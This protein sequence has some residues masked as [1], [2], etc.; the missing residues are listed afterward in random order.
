MDENTGF[1]KDVSDIIAVEA[2]KNPSL[3]PDLSGEK[4]IFIFSDYSWARGRYKTYSF[5]VLGRSGAD[6]FNTAR[7]VLRKDFGLENRRMSFKGLNDRVKLTALPAFLSLAGASDGFILTFAVSS[8]IPYMFAEQFLQVWPELAALKKPVLEDMLRIAHFGAQAV[9]IAF[10]PKQNI[11]WFTDED[12]IVANETHQQHFGR[13]A[14]AIIRKVLPDEEIGEI[15]FGLTGADD[16]SLEIEDLVAI[17]DLVAGALC[18]LLDALSKKGQHITPRI[19]L[20]N[21]E[22]SRKAELICQ[23]IG[24]THCPLK[25]FGMTFDATGS[26]TWDWRPTFFHIKNRNTANCETV[27][28]ARRRRSSMVDPIRF[29]ISDQCSNPEDPQNRKV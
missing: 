14:E 17:P 12:N 24:K 9:L 20:N 13:L 19:L 18:E 1:V 21:P 22:V 5:L 10:S 2:L 7:K 15:G 26:G 8:R 29:D 23:W 4:S 11:V 16:G 6:S 3:I 27:C 25:K 28:P